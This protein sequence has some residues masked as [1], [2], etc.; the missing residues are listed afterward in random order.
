MK[1]VE[2]VEYLKL[3]ECVEADIHPHAHEERATEFRARN[4]GTT[5]FEYLNLLHALVMAT[6]P[7]LALDTGTY[8]GA[9]AF[10]IASAMR[11]NGKGL[12]I[13]VDRDPSPDVAAQAEKC[14]V[15]DYI[16]FV[17]GD[18]LQFCASCL[19]HFDFGFFDT[20]LSMRQRE[21]DI[22]LRRRRIGCPFTAVFHDTSALRSS[23]DSSNEL[24]AY[25]KRFPNRLELPFS[26]GLTIVQLN[27]DPNAT[28]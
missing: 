21:F 15:K 5:E 1:W 18:S 28:G 13:S 14:C 27:Y 10:A 12:V 3:R 7:Q 6:K 9:S 17:K 11:E 22:L 24:R 8:H 23:G 16:R 20:E 26:R 25:L 4:S 19:E 2:M